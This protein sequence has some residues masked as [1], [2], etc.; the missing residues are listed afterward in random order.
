M[1]AVDT[2]HE[3]VWA[4]RGPYHWEGPGHCL[5][6]AAL[7][8]GDA[9]EWR[10]SAWTAMDQP[11]LKYWDWR[12]QVDARECYRQGQHP[13]QRRVLLGVYPTA[14]EAR[15]AC[16]RWL[17]RGEAPWPGGETQE[18][19]GVQPGVRR[20]DGLADDEVAPASLVDGL[21]ALESE[22]LA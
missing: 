9:A 12:M 4:R 7:V 18:D 21:A 11:E 19:A 2:E 3:A 1:I 8:G 20:P 5:V 6:S 15:Q 17:K 13:P 16:L 22:G 10:Y 14:A